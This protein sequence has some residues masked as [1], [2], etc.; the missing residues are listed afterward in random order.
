MA[1]FDVHRN[2]ATSLVATAPTTPTAGTSLV[3]TGGTGG[4]FPAVPFN[5][6]I[7]QA[8]VLPDPSNSEIVRVTAVSTDTLT[9]VRAQEGSTARTVG[10]GDVIYCSPTNKVF[11]DIETRMI[12]NW[13]DVTLQG[14]N[15]VLP[16]NTAAQNFTAFNALV[17]AASN[18]STIY[19]PAGIYLFGGQ[20]ALPANKMFT[21]QGQG[22]NRAGSPATAFTELRWNANVGGDLILLPGSGGGWYTQFRDLT[23]TAI[24]ADQ[25][26]GAVINVNGN[27]GTNIQN[28]S[29]QSAGAFFNVVLAGV[30]G[31]G[32]NSWNSAVIHNCN[33]QGYKTTGIVVNSSGS[34][35]VI[36]NTVIQGQWGGT[37]GTP[38]AA[39]ATAGIEAGNL[40][41]L[42]IANCD[43]LGNI[44]NI[45]CDP[46]AGLVNA[47][48]F[49]SNTY[50]DNSGGSCIKVNN[51]A[52]AT[53]RMKFEGCSFTTAG[54]NFTTPGTN[55]SAFEVSGAFAFT[56]TAGQG[57]DIN[58]CNILNTFG[59]TGTT[60]GILV[61]GGADFTVK[62]CNIA[63]WTNGLNVTPIA[64]LNVTKFMF[65]NNVC[66]TAAGYNGLTTGVLINAGGAA[67]K[68]YT[69]AHNDFNG[70][71]TPIS[72]GG[73]VSINGG[74]KFIMDNTGNA[75]GTRAFVTPGQSIATATETI[76][77]QLWCPANTIKAGTQFRG[78]LSMLPGAA[79]TTT[80]GI[81]IGTAGTISDLSSVLVGPLTGAGATAVW[82]T[83]NTSVTSPGATALHVGAGMLATAA[84]VSA[85]T[86]VTATTFSTT[87]GNWI[88]LTYKSSVATAGVIKAG[89]L[90]V[91]SP[92]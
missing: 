78:H 87:V 44:N 68:T 32:S 88:S 40:G 57:I 24:T 3:V 46:G 19:F 83:I 70:C 4:R 37:G 81:R 84:V 7:S 66:G 53:V 38:A 76:V 30:G 52:G 11:T 90:E 14:T 1:V 39:M 80:L 51:S 17:A 20:L 86:A 22:S 71:T 8:G 42:Q 12:S 26:G 21:F 10:V 45:L 35:L 47:S 28:C 72:D 27:V 2:L 55:L 41:A 79:Q 25:T 75:D 5:A 82:G 58:N 13:I 65:T 36:T 85:A 67:Y 74:Q 56:A 89:F 62:G 33:I 48:L 77:C 60:N 59:T 73:S 16:S 43:I 69:I 49:C 31:S 6:T 92:S 9:I 50:F 91:V 15:A 29:F 23:F 64:T 18:G 34:S 54:T 63:G 61:A